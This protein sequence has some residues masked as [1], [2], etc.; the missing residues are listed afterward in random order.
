MITRQRHVDLA[1]PDLP[2]SSASI[3]AQL[4]PACVRLVHEL[5][6]LDTRGAGQG[7]HFFGV[8]GRT[9]EVSSE[10]M[11]DQFVSRGVLLDAG[12]AVGDDH[13][14][15][16]DAFAI[17]EEHLQATIEAQGESAAVTRGNIVLLAIRRPRAPGPG[18]A[19]PDV[20]GTSRSPACP[21][22]LPPSPGATPGAASREHLPATPH[23]WARRL[24]RPCPAS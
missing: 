6:A 3:T 5:Q 17:T 23:T 9:V 20:P 2:R 11:A 14:E 13:G 7:F 12:R 21:A 8:A 24:T 1:V 15:L 19:A 16:A 10:H 4:A 18:M 22:D